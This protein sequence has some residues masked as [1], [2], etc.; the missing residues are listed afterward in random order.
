MFS[1]C[2]FVVAVRPSVRYQT[3]EHD[4]LKKEL[5]SRLDSRTLRAVNVLVFVFSNNTKNGRYQRYQ[6][7]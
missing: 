5:I 4:I 6:R 2:P 3:C 1:T 7:Y